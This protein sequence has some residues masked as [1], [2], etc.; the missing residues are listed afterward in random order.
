MSATRIRDDSQ[1]DPETLQREIDETRA[2][3]D[4]TIAALQAKLSPGQLLDQALGMLREHGGE[5]ARNLGGAVKQNPI[6][7]LLTGV[8]LAWMMASQRSTRARPA[9]E[10]PFYEPTAYEPPPFDASEGRAYDESGDGGPGMGERLKATAAG[11]GE[12]LGSTASGVSERVSSTAAGVRERLSGARQRVSGAAGSVSEGMSSAAESARYRAR[13]A[14]DEF[15]RLMDE[16]PLVLGALGLALGAAIGAALPATEREDRL[17]GRTSD[18]AK[19][20]ARELGTRQ[21]EQARET[22]RRVAEGAGQALS[23]N[24]ESA[25]AAPLPEES[26]NP[27]G[28]MPPYRPN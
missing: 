27:Y 13:R 12:R 17:L 8:G 15:G 11:V 19:R 22:A 16:Q 24:G 6:P 3:V 20:R 7:M 10:E 2:D 21:Y 9:Y 4:H 14:R 18:E 25:R 26:Q 23:G 5:F 28:E 1:K